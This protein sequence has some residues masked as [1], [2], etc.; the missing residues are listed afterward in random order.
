MRTEEILKKAN[1]V[2]RVLHIKSKPAEKEGGIQL[3]LVMIK[4]EYFNKKKI[5]VR[6]EVYKE[7]PFDSNV[8]LSDCNLSEFFSLEY[9]NET[10]LEMILLGVERKYNVDGFHVVT[11][12]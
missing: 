8:L 2:Q 5:N 9:K 6:K 10:E 3:S 4:D 1:E 7:A 11:E 12:E